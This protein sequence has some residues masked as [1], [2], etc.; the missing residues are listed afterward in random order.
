MKFFFFS[1]IF[2]IAFSYFSFIHNQERTFEEKVTFDP[3]IDASIL[4]ELPLDIV[5]GK[6]SFTNFNEGTCITKKYNCKTCN[7]NTFKL[8]KYQANISLNNECLPLNIRFSEGIF[9][10][11]KSSSFPKAWNK[12]GMYIRQNDTEKST[13]IIEFEQILKTL[14]INEFKKETTKDNLNT[15]FFFQIDN[16]Y[17]YALFRNKDLGMGLKSGLRSFSVS[18]NPSSFE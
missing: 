4:K 9:D 14:K 8:K 1:I 11:K 17:F 2:S 15:Y 10:L 3:T 6:T 18:L 7:C 16:Y 5:L 13:S 12:L